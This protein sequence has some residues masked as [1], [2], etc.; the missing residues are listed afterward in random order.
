MG[1]S[2]T[3]LAQKARTQTLIVDSDL[4]LGNYDLIT[5]DAKG[6]TAEF[7]EFIGGVGN[8]SNVLG[9]GNL[10]IEGTGNIK[11][12]TTFQNGVQVNGSLHVEGSINNV[13]IADNG[14]I[15]TAQGVNGTDFNGAK[16]TST[17]FNG[18]TIDA[19]G[20]VTG[21]KG[22]FSGAVAGSTINGAT[23]TST[24]FNGATINAS[25]DVTGRKFTR[26]GAVSV[27]SSTPTANTFSP[28]NFTC[29]LPFAPSTL[30]TGSVKVYNSDSSARPYYYY[31]NLD[32]SQSSVSVPANSVG[33][34]SFTNVK[35][36]Y[37]LNN[38][39]YFNLASLTLT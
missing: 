20:N 18:A 9:S 32:G 10:D 30:Y 4:N 7:D 33:T 27:T 35:C 6:D 13:N 39:R 15:T 31:T 8:F 34:I 3:A 14:E 26:T 25:G 5:T 29:L 28:I 2:I 23:I 19:S 38:N 21:V 16:I 22:T 36:L 17:K 11:G 37:V 1:F 24:K 12:L